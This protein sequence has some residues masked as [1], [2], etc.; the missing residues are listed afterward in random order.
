MNSGTERQVS[1][2]VGW[3]VTA[4]VGVLLLTQTFGIDGNTELAMLHALTPYW[5]VI[6][7]PLAGFAC[8]ASQH[9]LAL[10]TSLIGVGG[11]ALTAPLVF[12]STAPAPSADATGT[13]VAAVNLLYI[14]PV[15]DEAADALLDQD[16]DAIVFSEY[17]V[18][19]QSALNNH[20]L[21]AQYD[22]KVERD[23]LF[24]GGIAIWSRYPITE[25]ERLDTANYALDIEIDAPDGLFRLLGI[26]APTPIFDF[27]LW[28]SDLERFG[29]ASASSPQPILIIGDFNASYWHPSFRALLGRGL[30]DAHARAGLGFSTSWPTDQFF[31]PFVR[32]DHALTGNGLVSTG[33]VDFDVPGSDH[34]GL[35]VTVAPAR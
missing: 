21:A 13:T 25:R 7:A 33:V 34:L 24:S 3:L 28:R 8:W 26:H 30:L 2:F 10:V 32:L 11:L 35:V 5:L 12:T 17:T 20:P 19:H 6:T 23:G 14:N 16:A 22:F 18:E 27:D 4:V 9:R 31:P 29:E 15:I 1:L